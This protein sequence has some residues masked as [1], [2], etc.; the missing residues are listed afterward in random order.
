[1]R[2]NALIVLIVVVA[3]LGLWAFFN[4]PADPQLDFTGQ[5]KAVSFSPNR[6]DQDPLVN[7][8]PTPA[9]IS[10]DIAFLKGKAGAI[11]T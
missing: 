2:K 7:K 9:Q 8:F 6:A 1:M 3:N 5:V 10:E 4:R 11:R